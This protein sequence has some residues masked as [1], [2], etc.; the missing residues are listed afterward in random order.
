MIAG[1][2]GTSSEAVAAAPAAV[3][4]QLARPPVYR[5]R[6]VPVL[7]AVA[8][9]ACL[10]PM[11]FTGRYE[12]GVVNQA[13]LY[14]LL[15]VGFYHVFGLGGQFSFA[16]S[17]FFA[18]GAYSSVWASSHSNFWAGFVFAILVTGALA[19]AVRL[20]L[21]TSAIYFAIATLAFAELILIVL[22]NWKGFTGGFLGRRNIVPPSIFGTELSTPTRHFG[23]LLAVLVLALLVT[24]LLERSPVRRELLMARDMPMVAATAGLPVR[25]L[26]VLAFAVGS[27]MAGAAGSLFAHTSGF[28]SLA[29]FSIEVSLLVLLMLLLGGIGSAWGAVIGAIVL[30]WLPEQLRSVDDYAD[31]FYAVAIL[32]VIVAFPA[33]LVGIGAEVRKLVGR[34]ARRG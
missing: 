34:V 14:S 7:A 23:L 11:V 30:T 29:S 6:Q 1:E 21:R 17:G 8:A 15:T 28:I 12:L 9:L 3:V 32:V 27:S 26:E 13:L 2:P 19:A 31:V 4:A 24:A 10:V 18:V 16:H 25:R 5:R 33:G 22:R 20:A